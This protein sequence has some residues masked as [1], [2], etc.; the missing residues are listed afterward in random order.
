VKGT[1]IECCHGFAIKLLSNGFY[2]VFGNIGPGS[3]TVDGVGVEGK[4]PTAEGAGVEI[5]GTFKEGPD[6]GVCQI[7]HLQSIMSK[8]A[9]NMNRGIAIYLFY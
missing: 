1:V 2:N 3:Q 8:D 5:G 7:A 9:G 6:F 4:F